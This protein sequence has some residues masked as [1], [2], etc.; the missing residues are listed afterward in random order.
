MASKKNILAIAPA[1]HVGNVRDEGRELKCVRADN[2]GEYRGPFDKYCRDHGIRLEKTYPKTPQH[3]GVAE[4]IHRTIGERIRCILSH[5][6][7]P[8]SFLGEAVRTAV[9]NLSPSVPLKGDVPEREG[10]G[11]GKMCHMIT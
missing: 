7:L 4:R 2:G 9:V 5:V 10:C 3:N 11:W 8:K 6:K 1:R